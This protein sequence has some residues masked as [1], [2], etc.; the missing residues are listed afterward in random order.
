MT[1]S[2]RSHTFKGV[3]EFEGIAAVS[4]GTGCRG[5]GAFGVMKRGARVLISERLASGDF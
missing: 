1:S 5:E 3:F 2:G 4:A